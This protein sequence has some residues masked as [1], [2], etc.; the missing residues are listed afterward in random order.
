MMLDLM[1]DICCGLILMALPSDGNGPERWQK[2]FTQQYATM[3]TAIAHRDTRTLG[4][5][6]TPDFVA[7]DINGAA[8]DKQRLLAEVTDLPDDPGRIAATQLL[9]VS[10]KQDDNT[11][12]IIHKDTVQTRDRD[13]NGRSHTVN[14]IVIISDDWV[15]VYTLWLL[16]HRETTVYDLFVDGKQT[17][18]RL[19]GAPSAITAPF[20][21]SDTAPAYNPPPDATPFNNPAPNNAIFNGV[22]DHQ[23]ELQTP[24]NGDVVP[25]PTPQ[26][27]AQSTLQP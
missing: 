21:Q 22:P 10:I 6:L 18:H 13:A 5:L 8:T 3:Q 24:S 4:I 27:D 1:K 15:R 19:R 20:A 26:P 2:L 16:R 7:Y 25:F 17:E 9:S 12:R 23:T 11:A 14:M